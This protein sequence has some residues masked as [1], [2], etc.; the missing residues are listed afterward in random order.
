MKS[1][2]GI[3]VSVAWLFT[4]FVT[5]G[6]VYAY[7][8]NNDDSPGHNI[9]ASITPQDAYE[10][11]VDA[12]SYLYPLITM[13]VTR[14][15]MTL[16]SDKNKGNIVGANQFRHLRAYPD[17]NFKEVVR[18]NFDTLYSTAWLDLTK[19]PQIVSAPDTNGRYYLL[20]MLDMWSNVFA[21]PGK[22]TTGT[23]PGHWAVIPLGW[24]GSLPEGVE[25]INAPTPYVW[26]L[27]RTQTNGPED[28]AAVHKIQDGL[29]IT[30]L[31][32]WGKSD[33]PPVTV[34]ESLNPHV[35]TT[36]I[37]LEQVNA[38]GAKEY[39]TYG[40]ELLQTIPP[41][42]TDWSILSRLQKLGIGQGMKFSFDSLSPDIQVEL[43]R[44]VKDG[45]NKM[46]SSGPSLVRKSNGWLMSTESTGVYGNDY[47]KRAV[48]ALVGLGANNP[49]DAV[50]P[51]L[52]TDDTGA[53]LEGGKRYV[54]H[55]NKNSTPPTNA[56]WSITMYD[57]E[58]FPV[59]NVLN[60]FTISSWMPLKRDAD[61][62]L[63]IY[64]QPDNPGKDK[65]SNWLP[66]PSEGRLGITMRVYWP[67]QSIVDGGWVPPAAKRLN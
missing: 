40:S 10:I 30:A 60:R 13:D 27:G 18:P 64:I 8:G 41:Q 35:N 59:T 38:M 5:I 62:S 65:E 63:E 3:C 23:G 19:E 20:P 57:Q 42:L 34:H 54:L 6:S 55:F 15:V 12:Y 52:F 14:N 53:P 43:E 46:K 56:F 51:V 45:L 29:K 17:V 4:S 31:S 24:K 49:V 9:Y 26:I 16:T 25:K 61:G 47:L 36:E 21:T 2:I 11:G 37:P 58:G 33:A 67:Q 66:S 39:F 48:I 28:Y 7:A 44:A 50:Y 32:Q 22:R 1:S